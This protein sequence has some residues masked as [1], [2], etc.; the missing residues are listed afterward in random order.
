MFNKLFIVLFVIFVKNTAFA[1][2]PKQ[3][4]SYE[5][6]TVAKV[7]QVIE[8]SHQQEASIWP[9]Y[10]LSKTPVVIW[11]TNG[12]IYAFNL[13]SDDAHWKKSKNPNVKYSS[14]D[15][16]GICE[17]EMNPEYLLAGQEVYVFHIDLMKRDPVLPFL[18]L[19]HE[20]FHSHQFGQFSDVKGFTDTYKDYLNVDNIALIRLEDQLLGQYTLSERPTDRMELLKD[21]LAIHKS[22]MKLIKPSS[23][24]WERHQQRMEGLADYV[25]FKTLETPGLMPGYHRKR[26]LQSNLDSY[27][28]NPDAVELAIKH[29]HYGVGAALGFALDDI[30]LKNWKT[31]IINNQKAMDELL[32]ESVVLSDSEVSTRAQKLK[33]KYG[34][35]NIKKDVAVLLTRYKQNITK[36]MDG[37]HAQTGVS[38]VIH[39]PEGINTSGG[40]GDHGMYYIDEGILSV[41]N[42]TISSTVDNTWQIRLDEVSYLLQGKQGERT[43]KVEEGLQVVLDGENYDLQELISTA[44]ARPFTT[45]TWKGKNSEFISKANKGILYTKK[46]KVIVDF[47]NIATT[48]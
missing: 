25:S 48:L 41:G 35:E 30:G 34:F 39:Q 47:K 21:F 15:Y 11:F 14:H 36:L 8:V 27:A 3:P 7:A 5:E 9:G 24:N 45:L 10:D 33:Q 23:A 37:Y 46:G 42:S 31:E 32:E 13:N 40:G 2:G 20:R 38:M 22:R 19:V 18:V 16:W 26:H 29:R 6:Q 43:F 12:H 17:V 44:A 28:K 1:S 4:V